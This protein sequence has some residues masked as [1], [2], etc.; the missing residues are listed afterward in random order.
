M[1]STISSQSRKKRVVN[2]VAPHLPPVGD[3]SLVTN[4]VK[5][6]SSK[7]NP[8]PKIKQETSGAGEHKK[9]LYLFLIHW[10]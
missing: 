5:V 6:V 9:C 7:K 4:A 3:A 2:A 1:S 8:L 10:L